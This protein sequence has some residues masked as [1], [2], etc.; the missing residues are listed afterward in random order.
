MGLFADK[1]FLI[2]FES[3]PA[4][5]LMRFLRTGRFSQPIQARRG[6]IVQLKEHFRTKAV[7]FRVRK[8]LTINR[9]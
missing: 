2:S 4:T 3:R 1:T 9:K 8:R 6:E 5:S 7:Q